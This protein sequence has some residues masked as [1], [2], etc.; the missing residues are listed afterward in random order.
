MSTATLTGR[1]EAW[2]FAPFDVFAPLLERR[3][4]ASVEITLSDGEHHGLV[5]VGDD[6]S[7]DIHVANHA[8]ASIEISLQG[9]G[10]ANVNVFARTGVGAALKISILGD[11]DTSAVRRVCVTLMP[12]RD[13]TIHANGVALN[14]R[15]FRQE[16]HVQFD[17]PG[18][19]VELRGLTFAAGED[20]LEQRLRVVHNAPHCT[21][22]VVY[23]SAAADTGHIVWV[24]DI[25]ITRE[26][27]AADT[28]ELNRNLVLSAGA[29][30]DSV[31]NLELETGEV[32]GAGHASATGRFDDEQLFYLQARGIPSD[33]ARRMVVEG[34]FAEL[35]GAMALGEAG[36]K[37]LANIHARLEAQ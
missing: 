29:R 26:G 17:E 9:A 27:T 5:N 37:V 14:G 13:S 34:F 7:W 6:V 22:N 1:E 10:E 12:G 36:E 16:T 30:V 19:Q 24:G 3:G 4:A 18:A 23:K 25:V 28:Y 31:P 32:I 35:L 15:A 8:S 20:Y 33:V 11:T 2:R 21:S